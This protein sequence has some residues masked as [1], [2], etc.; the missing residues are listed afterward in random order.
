MAGPI[1]LLPY[2]PI[3]TR[4]SIPN[5]CPIVLIIVPIRSEAKRPCA[6][7]PRA[8]IP[9][10]LALILTSFFSRKARTPVFLLSDFADILPI[11]F[12]CRLS[13]F[14]IYHYISNVKLQLRS[15][16]YFT[17]SFSCGPSY[18]SR[19]ASAAVSHII[20]E[21]LLCEAAEIAEFLAGE[22][23]HSLFVLFRETV[24]LMHDFDDPDVNREAR[25]I[26]HAE[27]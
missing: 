1:A 5:C 27:K 2:P 20:E 9:Y 14:F 13:S 12:N 10:R 17:S 15:I 19:Q 3:V 11:L 7:A 23:R 21:I 24:K 4:A 16:I 22:R 18:T 25:V 6:I 8:S 26:L